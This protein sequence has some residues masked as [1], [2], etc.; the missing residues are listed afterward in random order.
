MMMLLLLLLFLLCPH[1]RA[2]DPLACV[3]AG[4]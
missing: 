2:V 4:V 1:A 3:N